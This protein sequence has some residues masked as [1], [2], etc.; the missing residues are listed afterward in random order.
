LGMAA[1]DS[2]YLAYVGTYTEDTN[3]KGIYAFHF[4]SATGK[5]SVVELAAETPNPSFLT[6]DKDGK[7]L[8]AVNEL[9]IYNGNMAG[10][11]TVFGINAASGKLDQLQ[12]VSSAGAAPAH[13]SID[14][15]GKYV[16][17]A[18]YDSGN[19]AVFPIVAD[20]KLG[21]RSGFFQNT[22]SSVNKERQKS[23]HAHEILAIDSDR[24]VLVPDLGSDEL[25]VFHFD[26]ANGS[27]TPAKPKGFKVTPG[28]GPRHFAMAPSGKYVYLVNEMAS[29][30]M[31][32]KFD[33]ESGKL[34]HEQTISTL[35]VGTAVENTT[36]EIAV[37]AAGKFLYVSN[38]GDDSIAVFAIAEKDGK[39]TFV[40]RVPT[41][42]KEPRHFTFDPTGKWL[43]AENQESD[44]ITLFAVDAATGKL[45]KTDEIISVA[46][47]VCVVFV[48]GT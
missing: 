2:S 48:P 6:V 46:S 30:V 1:A 13:I 24:F 8:Y 32:L 17:V 38:R 4:D 26:S 37:D 19:V 35:P 27:L 36:A 40:E 10:G 5:G 41:G 47:P 22:G 20:G 12:Q 43:L 25:Q 39:L 16:L 15:S 3:S 28:S 34:H 21:Q 33:A 9:D 42:G 45:T 14:S 18:N 31:V 7:Y 11:V 23:P 29:T 44:T